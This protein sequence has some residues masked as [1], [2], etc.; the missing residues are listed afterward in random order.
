[1]DITNPDLSLNKNET[2]K[3]YPE[4]K[5]TYNFEGHYINN[6]H[7]YYAECPAIDGALIDIGINGWLRRADALKIYEMAYFSTG[8][9][10]EFGSYQGLSTSILSQANYDSGL[11]KEIHSIEINNSFLEIS[12]QNLAMRGLEKNVFF[13]LSDS[14]DAVNELTK[15]N[16]EFG[17]IFID[18]SHEYQPVLDVCN[19]LP[20]LLIDGGFCLFHDYIHPDTFNL[21]IKDFK[22][23]QAVNDGLDKKLFKFCGFFGCT[24]LFQLV[25]NPILIAVKERM[26]SKES[27]YPAILDK[28]VLNPENGDLPFFIKKLD[29]RMFQGY[30]DRCNDEIIDGWAWN[31]ENPDMPIMLEIFDKDNLISRVNANKFRLDL[32]F[33]KLGN[34][35]HGF[36]FAIPASLMDDNDHTISVKYENSGQHLQGS[37]LIIHIKARKPDAA[38]KHHKPILI[39]PSS[40]SYH[41]SEGELKELT[42]KK[43]RD[44]GEL[45]D[46]RYSNI[47]TVIP[48][49]DVVDLYVHDEFR[50]GA[51]EYDKK[52]SNPAYM[53]RLITDLFKRL[54]R[55][56]FNKK[57][58]FC[59]EK[60][61]ILDIGSGSGNSIFPLLEICPFSRIIA[62]DLSPDMLFL[63]KNNRSD[64]PICNNLSLLQLNAEDLAFKE[65]SFDI[66]FGFSVLHHLFFPEITL[67][68]CKKILRNDGLAIFFEPFEPGH[69]ILRNIFEE[70]LSDSRSKS[71]SPQI[72][73][74][75]NTHVQIFDIQKGTDKSLSCFKH[76][77]DKWVFTEK[78]FEGIAATYGFTKPVIYNIN[79]SETPLEN[80]V[81]GLERILPGKAAND[82]LP[83]W[84]WEKIRR[85]DS[86]LSENERWSLLFEGCIIMQKRTPNS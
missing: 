78:Y 68:Q 49:Q 41:H 51:S 52:N 16:K 29:I 38:D 21:A 65:N 39:K 56:P 63:L 84:A 81:K 60:L 58:D 48:D 17:F 3:Y 31:S 70:I 73:N 59:K 24:A 54:E 34:G 14:S 82:S 47:Y 71:I 83:D 1:M 33:A 23:Y 10:L 22:V 26:S 32:Y 62:S 80:K 67:E 36:S 55:E 66:V 9:V 4:Y 2:G 28:T 64:N 35:E 57:H 18:H 6:N 77:E 74:L 79:P 19:S 86:D 85:F 30:V 46:T 75:L 61:K 13:H 15:Y 72:V 11:K 37:P 53:V 25:R 20:D 50:S 40:I 8:A 45:I 42:T 12:K 5:K 76:I 43:I 69:E 44:L 27:Q 7:K